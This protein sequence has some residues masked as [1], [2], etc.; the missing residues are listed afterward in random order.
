MYSFC[1]YMK[2]CSLFS[3]LIKSLRHILL[4]LERPTNNTTRTPI[5]GHF[6]LTS[7]HTSELEIFRV[8]SSSFE[9]DTRTRYSYSN[10]SKYSG[11]LLDTRT[12]NTRI[13]RVSYSKLGIEIEFQ[14]CY[15]TKKEFFLHLYHII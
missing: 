14:S 8:S 10:Y 6:D 4:T 5:S 7:I 1:M 3:S 12:C 11:T 13:T 9:Y 15:K 2:F